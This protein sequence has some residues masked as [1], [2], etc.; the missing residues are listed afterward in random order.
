MKNIGI[1]GLFAF[2]LTAAAVASVPP[3]GKTTG[4]TAIYQN[5]SEITTPRQG[6][7]S[8]DQ[9]LKNLNEMER[10]Y[11]ERLPRLADRP[12]LASPIKRISARKYK[13]SQRA[14]RATTKKSED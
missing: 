2:G 8:F 11:H 4:D 10:K 7:L 5:N 6:R 12:E 14:G 1:I 3:T 9:D 13:A